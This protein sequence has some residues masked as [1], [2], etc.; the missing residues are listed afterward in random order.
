MSDSVQVPASLASGTLLADRYEV[1]RELGR[2]GMGV[3]YL[4]RD[5]YSGAAVA[6]K[7]L[8]KGG[9]ATDREEAWW[10]QLEARALASLN[11]PVIVRARDFGEL[12]DSTPFLVMDVAPGRS[13]L[14]WLEMGAVPWPWPFTVLWSI[15]DQILAALAHAHARGIIHGD[16]KP[17]NLMLDFPGPS[18]VPS[19]FILDLGLASLLRHSTDRLDRAGQGA[20]VIRAGAGTPGWMA[21]EQIRSA[22]THYGPATDLYAL[23]SILYH[24]VSGKEPWSGPP[25]VV[26]EGHK[27][28]PL[29]DFSMPDSVPPPVGDFVRKLLAKRPWHRFAYAGDARRVWAG[30]RPESPTEPWSFR[31]APPD[32]VEEISSVEELGSGDRPSWSGKPPG[33]TGSAVGLLG[34]RR[35]PFVARN[36]ERADL[37]AIVDEIAQSKSAMQKFVLLCGE[38]G[39]GKSRLA[40][41]LCE[42][43]HENALMVPLRARYRRIPAP[44]DGVRGAIN[45]HFCL[46]RA[47]RDLVEKTLLNSWEIADSDDDGRTWVAAV[48]EWLRP[49]PPGHAVPVG[50]TGKR[51]FFDSVDVRRKFI[52]RTLAKIGEDR[53]ILLW[54]DDLY[55]AS[56]RTFE[57]LT[58]LRSA[59]PNL[60]MLMIVTARSEAIAVDQEAWARLEGLR[61]MYG[62]RVIEMRALS[63]L[64]TEALLLSSLP[65]EE[66]AVRRATSRSGGNPLFALQLLHAWAARHHFEFANGRYR[67]PPAALE[68]QPGSTAE[69]WDERLLAI[70]P[71][72]RGA[73]LSAAALGGD[74]PA[75]V[76]KTLLE[77]L[78][79]P[80]GPAISALQ[81]AQILVPSGP[82]RMR[83]PHAL[84]QEHL[85]A[86]LTERPEAKLVFRRAADALALHPAAGTRRV[87]GHRV[88]NMLRAGDNDVASETVL[89]F[90]E[91]NWRRVRDAGGTL[92]DLARIQDVVSGATGAAHARWR[93]EALRYVGQFA[94]ARALAERAR[95]A[96]AT[97]GDRANEAHCLRLLGDILA[98]QSVPAGRDHVLRA[99]SEL[100]LLGDAAGRAECELVLGEIDWLRG[101]DESARI[102]LLHASAYFTQTGD[103]L[104]KGQC[105]YRMGI[106]G[107]SRQPAQ[108]KAMLDEAR[109]EFDKVGYRLGLAQCE[110]AYGLLAQRSDD[111][112]Q[113][114][115]RGEAARKMM[116]EMK[117][118]RGEAAAHRLLAMAALDSGD[119]SRSREHALSAAATYDQIGEPRGQMEALL[120]LAQ[121]ALASSAGVAGD[122]LRSCEAFGLPD[123]EPK[124]H[125]ELTKAWLWQTEKMEPEAFAAVQ[126]ARLA[127]GDPRRVADHTRQ[128]IGRLAQFEWS[129]EGHALLSTWQR[130]L[131]L[132]PRVKMRRK[133]RAK[134]P[135]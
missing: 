122:L 56:P 40:E 9:S 92:N 27:N 32:T 2:G 67:V 103:P 4:C 133:P 38:A 126:T 35:S 30:F 119:A 73:A 81:R 8:H 127:F 93:A 57:T 95:Q 109:T 71:E 90:V 75:S 70:P 130:E 99:L 135:S 29:P 123:S 50:P 14:S 120:L 121:V 83:W 58:K 46:E 7:S 28:Q 31:I 102:W 129:G 48:A 116:Q 110:I 94:E 111:F 47:N 63:Q 34:L 61:L 105:L 124:Q 23:G 79:I 24:L 87:V 89:R 101:H 106:A 6:L 53:P 12:E 77:A 41:V 134:R 44:L 97:M 114:L 37:R 100:D 128:L 80:S 10:F 11:H 22:A 25:E 108:A 107:L 117:N 65:L 21:P 115:D 55:L 36:E 43:V 125:L 112:A 3:V 88:T 26:L 39:V 118:G 62:G 131:G 72:L 68:E 18:S 15:V 54:L 59:A 20:P 60:R 64:D 74:I 76:L 49:T 19:V 45:A 52:Y 78:H 132:R 42:E 85:L 13:L 91:E 1:R 66:P 16:L 84:L 5:T 33:S 82:G 96:F 113:A 104:G 51:F 69:L 86:R 98:T 17:T